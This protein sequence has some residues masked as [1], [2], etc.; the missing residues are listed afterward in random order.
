MQLK[1]C[2]ETPRN[3]EVTLKA[4]QGQHHALPTRGRNNHP[5]QQHMETTPVGKDSDSNNN[6][7]NNRD[8]DNNNNNNKVNPVNL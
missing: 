4:K 8:D 5:R 6:N 1:K 7:N 2:Q 3:S